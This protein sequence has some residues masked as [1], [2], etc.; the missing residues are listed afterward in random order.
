MRKQSASRYVAK[1][2]SLSMKLLAISISALFAG[3]N[4]A[5]ALSY[6]APDDQPCRQSSDFPFLVFLGVLVVMALVSKAITYFRQR[7]RR[8]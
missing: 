6:C 5:A 1:R 2:A 8:K 4:S 3:V 7:Q